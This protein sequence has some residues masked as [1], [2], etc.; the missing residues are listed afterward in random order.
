MK[1]TIRSQSKWLALTL[2]SWVAGCSRGAEEIQSAGASE[3]SVGPTQSVTQTV[4]LAPSVAATASVR[5]LVGSTGSAA[6][7]GAATSVAPIDV[8]GTSNAPSPGVS[9]GATGVASQ[10]SGVAASSGTL[11]PGAVATAP[12]SSTLSSAAP[13][14]ST[15]AGTQ[16][17]VNYSLSL[18][19]S[20]AKLPPAHPTCGT[21]SAGPTLQGCTASNGCDGL[22]YSVNCYESSS[23]PSDCTCSPSR[24]GGWYRFSFD[25]DCEKA[26]MVCTAAT[27]PIKNNAKPQC[28]LSPT[29]VEGGCIVHQTCLTD[30]S[31]AG[32]SGVLTQEKRVQCTPHPQGGVDCN[33]DGDVTQGKVVHLPGVIS[34]QT[35]ESGSTACA[36][37]RP[38][39]FEEQCAGF[40]SEFDGGCYVNSYC[41]F[42]GAL[43]GGA[44]ALEGD[45]W[46][47]R[48][49]QQG[50]GS[51][52]CSC[53]RLTMTGLSRD[54][55]AGSKTMCRDLISLCTAQP[56][57]EASETSYC[58]SQ[59][60]ASFQHPF[61]TTKL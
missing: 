51:W 37:D 45:T 1:L 25:G 41:V 19:G 55:S 33:C 22:L 10:A 29:S 40:P 11:G 31:V 12:S 52:S 46:K 36:Q 38:A 44:L 53:S 39:H 5:L 6:Q 27:L 57:A 3:S 7:T 50:A 34:E 13:A 20:W 17:T 23:G 4:A 9:V 16:I 24:E 2:L 28:S 15:S 21:V 48:C 35:C 49:D 56:T 54:F 30:L 32:A 8:K 14:P 47:L 42:S 58:A 43:P 61:C 59:D 60:P 26:L 18:P